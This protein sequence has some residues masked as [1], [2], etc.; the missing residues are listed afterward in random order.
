MRLVRPDDGIPLAGRSGDVWAPSHRCRDCRPVAVWNLS[1]DE[2]IALTP[3]MNAEAVWSA[4]IVTDDQVVMK[5][6]E[7]RKFA[8]KPMPK[9]GNFGIP[10]KVIL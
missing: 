5:L 9:K 3:T 6:Q 2:A 10:Q 4:S 7:P 8:C 1:P